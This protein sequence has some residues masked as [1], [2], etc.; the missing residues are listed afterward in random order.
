[1]EGKETN[2]DKIA[3]DIE[4]VRHT[5]E[6]LDLEGT[7]D[8]SEQV[9]GSIKRAEDITEVRFNEQ[10]DRLEQ[11]QSQSQEFEGELENRRGSSESDL[12][13][14][15]DAGTR[16]ETKDTVNELLKAKEAALRDIDFLAKQLERARRAREKS[17]DIQKRLNAVIKNKNRRS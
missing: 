5:L 10:D 8:G 16:T 17:D 11:I 3:S 12:Q 6:N 7:L 14:V 2:L 13:K 15:S 1:M 4:T 9:E